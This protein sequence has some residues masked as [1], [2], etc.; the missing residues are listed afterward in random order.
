MSIT[1]VSRRIAALRTLIQPTTRFLEVSFYA[2]L[3][4]KPG[5]SNFA[6]GNPH[7]MPLPALVESLQRWMVPQDK[8]WYAYK[9]GEPR[10]Q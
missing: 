2:D 5:V 6:L 4:N 8:D 10:S 7:E 3:V 1:S 9:M